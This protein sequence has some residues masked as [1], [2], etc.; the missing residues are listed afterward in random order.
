MNLTENKSGDQTKQEVDED[1]VSIIVDR[2]SKKLEYQSRNET[3]GKW[4]A[5]GDTMWKVIDHALLI[6]GDTL[7][8]YIMWTSITTI[9][10]YIFG[11]L[12]G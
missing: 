7:K 12:G 11:G 10:G 6:T 9:A 3:L 1:V 8:S 5:V 4:K 2:I